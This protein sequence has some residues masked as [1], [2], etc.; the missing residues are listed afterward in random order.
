MVIAYSLRPLRAVQPPKSDLHSIGECPSCHSSTV[1]SDSTRGQVSEV[2]EVAIPHLWYQSIRN[3]KQIC[4]VV[5]PTLDF[6]HGSKGFKSLVCPQ[7]N[8]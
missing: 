8:T 2:A 4:G 5:R 6:A 3:L 1:V 7:D